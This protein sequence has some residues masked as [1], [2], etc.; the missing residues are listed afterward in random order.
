MDLT[1][2]RLI[3]PDFSS[4]PGS[5]YNAKLARQ[6]NTYWLCAYVVVGASFS[7]W[8][9]VCDWHRK[10]KAQ[11]QKEELAKPKGVLILDTEK[12]V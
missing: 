10:I 7:V 4:K 12:L 6:T 2:Q 3:L 11:R 5:P 8:S 9:A 1:L